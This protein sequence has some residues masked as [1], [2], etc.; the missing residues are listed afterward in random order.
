MRTIHKVAAVVIQDDTFLMVRKVGKDIWTSLGGHIEKNETEEQ[1][2]LRE[3]K[4]ELDC[5]GRIIRKLGDFRAKAAFDNAEVLLSVYLMTIMGEP[6]ISDPE[7]EEFR[8]IDKEYASKGVTLPDSIVY[9]VL[10]H[11]IQS[12]LLHW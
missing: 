2:L 9:H 8:F 10:P 3:A 4:E 1:A 12:G 11:C 6:K 7:L 5:S